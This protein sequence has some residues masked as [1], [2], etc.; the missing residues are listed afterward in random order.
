MT[1]GRIP[2]V[3]QRTVVELTDDLDG[4]EA[5]DTIR[6]GLDGVAYAIDLNDEHIDAFRETLDPYLSAARRADRDAPAPTRRAASASA[7]PKRADLAEV[8]SWAVEQGWEISSRGRVPQQ[9]LD[10]YDAR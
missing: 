1:R 8:R 2:G 5:T 6:F 10:A 7:S 4:S 3:V 9:V